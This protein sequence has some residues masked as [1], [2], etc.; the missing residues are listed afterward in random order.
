MFT[1][2]DCIP[3]PGWLQA[4]RHGGLRG[5]ARALEG[6][7]ISE[8]GPRSGWDEAPLNAAG[9]CFWSCNIA[10]EAQTFWRAG[11]FDEHYPF[12]A[13]EDVDLRTALARL[14]VAPKFL[15]DAIVNHPARLGDLKLRLT[16]LEQL[17]S[18]VYYRRKWSGPH[19]A[20]AYTALAKAIVRHWLLI[21]LR[22]GCPGLALV[23]PLALAYM[24]VNFTRW[25]READRVVEAQRG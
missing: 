11:G 1:D 18:Q 20:A 23:A 25:Y 24:T 5:D 19:P 14:G 2:D 6:R 8:P 12:A 15:A 13:M 4:Y 21:P 22:Q 16:R 9:G 7:V 17:R 10:V 3:S